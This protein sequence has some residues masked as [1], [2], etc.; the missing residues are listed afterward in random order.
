MELPIKAMLDSNAF[1]LIAAAD[2]W[3]LLVPLVRQG[4]L[5][6]LS[7]PV[8][9]A[10]IAAIS[11]ARKRRQLQAIPRLVC[12]VPDELDLDLGGASDDLILSAAEKYADVL[13]TQDKVLTMR[14]AQRSTCRVTDL[15]GLFRLLVQLKSQGGK[16]GA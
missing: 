10:E 9:E 14:C 1:D 4:Y 5:Q 16:D 12:P 7:T 11:D 2:V 13:V 15:D 6:F 8:Q 3:P